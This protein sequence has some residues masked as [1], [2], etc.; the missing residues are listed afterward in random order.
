VDPE[1]MGPE[2]TE[3]TD[4]PTDDAAY[5]AIT[6]LASEG[7]SVGYHDGSY[8]PDRH[9]T[10]AEVATILYRYETMIANED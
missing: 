2:D 4:V 1:H 8:Q 7:L 10:R 5:Q 9:I 6:W 3:F